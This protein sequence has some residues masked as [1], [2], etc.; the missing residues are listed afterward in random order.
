MLGIDD[1]YLSEPRGRGLGALPGDFEPGLRP[2][3]GDGEPGI[4]PAP[5][6][7]RMAGSRIKGLQQIDPTV[8]EKLFA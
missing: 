1:R 4:R 7:Y 3:L 6:D 2:L 5:G 8:F